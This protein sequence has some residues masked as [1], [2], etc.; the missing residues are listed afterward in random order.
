MNCVR[1]ETDA[2]G[3]IK[4]YILQR[5][6]EKSA[7]DTSAKK[8]AAA[9]EL[10]LTPEQLLGRL[11]RSSS[12]V[13]NVICDSQGRLQITHWNTPV[14]AA[15]PQESYTVMHMDRKVASV[16][17]NGTCT[18]F[19]KR[20]M[21]YDLYLEPCGENDIDGRMNNLENFRYWCS[22]R[23]ITLERK[24]AKEILNSIGAAQLDTDRA[25]AQ[26]ALSYHALSLTDVFWVK[27]HREESSFSG[28][29]LY[30]NS[31][32]NSFVDISLRG[33]QITVDNSGKLADNLGT[34]GVAPKAWIRRD[35]TFWLLKDGDSKEV[36]NELLASRICRCFSV[37]QVLYEPDE[38][39]G[40]P[41]SKSKIITSKE[42][43]MLNLQSFEVYAVNHGIDKFSY[44]L[45]KDGYSYYMMNILDYL[46]GNTDRHWGNWGF[47]VDN[48][49][50]RI[51]KLH[52]LMDFNKSFLSYD[53]VDGANCLTSP[54]ICTQREA[55]IEAVRT[56]G[57]NRIAEVS[58]E[59]FPDQDTFSMFRKRLDILKQEERKT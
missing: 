44:I 54:A 9:E 19:S 48:A 46:V 27:K 41:V 34:A 32:S 17:K 2:Q 16:R 24:Y 40:L 31:L 14:S 26:T 6:A 39:D 43:S 51:L 45:K 8:S 37:D 53:S 3:K 5:T 55:A 20:F 10:R 18:L 30:D 25:R 59:W 57:L 56:V 13:N 29:N 22:S 12:Y 33:K 36:R 49:S 28:I 1:T 35:G 38:Y 47:L 15:R 50:N 11:N 21:P 58:P 23:V 42:Q 7:G 4:Y 52:P